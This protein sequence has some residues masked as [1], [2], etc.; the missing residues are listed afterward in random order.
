[1]LFLQFAEQKTKVQNLREASDFARYDQHPT[2]L[3]SLLSTTNTTSHYIL[4]LM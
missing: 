3:H 2:G 1:M 4:R